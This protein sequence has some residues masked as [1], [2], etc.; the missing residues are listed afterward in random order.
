LETALDEV[1]AQNERSVARRCGLTQTKDVSEKTSILLVRFR[2]QLQMKRRGEEATRPLLA[3]E[4]RSL[5][6]TGTPENPQWLDDEEADKL[7][8]AKP[9]GNPKAALVKQQLQHLIESYETHLQPVVERVAKERAGQLGKSHTQV[10]KSTKQSGKIDCD[11]VDKADVLGCF[12]L[13]PGN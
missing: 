6:F 5:A 9:S 3:E 8:D 11:P 13:L 10:R 2:Y 12:I 7:L 1:Q 4:V